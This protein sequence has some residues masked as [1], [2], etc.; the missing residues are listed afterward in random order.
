VRVLLVGALHE[1]TVHFCSAYGFRH[2]AV[3][4]HTLYLPLGQP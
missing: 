4:S 1:K 3:L 2:A